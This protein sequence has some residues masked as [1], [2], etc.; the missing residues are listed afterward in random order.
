MSRPP[1]EALVVASV[2]ADSQ[3]HRWLSGAETAPF[4]LWLVDYRPHPE[5]SYRHQAQL[6]RTWPGGK[7]QN[8]ARLFE[9]ESE[10]LQRYSAVF[11]PDDDLMLT[12]PQIG[13]LL[14]TRQRYD[15]ELAQPA[16]TWDSL[17]RWDITRRRPHLELRYTNFV[18]NGAVL[19]SASAL[20]RL[21]PTF[22][23][24]VSGFGLDLL[25]PYLLGYPRDRI[26]VLDAVACRHPHRQSPGSSELDRLLPRA[27]H[28][29]EGERLL[30]GLAL[31]P[32]REYGFRLSA[33][34]QALVRPGHEARAVRR[35]AELAY[36]AFSSQ[37]GQGARTAP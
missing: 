27:E 6:S 5:P 10:A 8:L 3:H 23:R 35:N 30:S 12:A 17:A 25:W 33:E 29:A 20:E 18:E 15:L 19:F 26:A 13:A 22:T 11:C 28:A 1:Q 31:E 16:F 21:R 37:G 34:G 24:S 2:G 9:E 4:D 14:E 36:R 7:W 32:V